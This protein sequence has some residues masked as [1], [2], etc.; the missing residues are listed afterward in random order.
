MLKAQRSRLYRKPFCIGDLTDGLRCI[1][2][3][4]NSLRGR[5][6]DPHLC[7]ELGEP[8]EGVPKLP[9]V[10]HEDDQDADRHAASYG[11]EELVAV[12]EVPAVPEDDCAPDG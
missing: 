7:D 9:D 2:H 10:V 8:L 3:V 4:E 5:L 12:H 11:L 1:H 6:E